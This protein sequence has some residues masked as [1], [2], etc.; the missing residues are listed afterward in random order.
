MKVPD[1][2]SVEALRL[3]FFD[4]LLKQ[5]ISIDNLQKEGKR[6]WSEGASAT[7]IRGKNYDLYVPLSHEE[8]LLIPFKDVSRTEISL[9]LLLIEAYEY[10]GSSYSYV[11]KIRDSSN[12][13]GY[14]KSGLLARFLATIRLTDAGRSARHQIH[15]KLIQMDAI[16]AD[17]LQTEND[18]T[19]REKLLQIIQLIGGN[20]FLLKSFAA[21][22]DFKY[23][24]I[25][26][27]FMDPDSGIPMEATSTRSPNPLFQSLNDQFNFF[28]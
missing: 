27:M 8:V 28:V 23:D 13:I 18:H 25:L 12:L 21:E 6:V 10:C 9:R 22:S 7:I 11:Y 1:V 20:I 24:S 15:D 5:V 3:T 2:T 16:L 17:Q 19:N 4:L 26:M 14:F